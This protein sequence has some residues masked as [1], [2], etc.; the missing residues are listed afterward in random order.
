MCVHETYYT[1][2]FIPRNMLFMCPICCCCCSCCQWWWWLFGRQVEPYISYAKMINAKQK[3][4]GKMLSKLSN[5]SSNK[6]V[7]CE[8]L[9]RRLSLSMYYLTVAC[10]RIARLQ[11]FFI[12]N[13]QWKGMERDKFSS[14]PFVYLSLFFNM[15]ESHNNNNNKTWHRTRIIILYIFYLCVA[16]VHSSEFALIDAFSKQT[17]A[18]FPMNKTFVWSI[19]CSV[20]GWCQ[21]FWRAFVWE[22]F[23][24]IRLKLDD[25]AWNCA[26][27][28]LLTFSPLNHV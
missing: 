24:L 25:W 15:V 14:I 21:Q 16:D 13:G 5:I 1:Q 23:R 19:D 26:I 17:L 11:P 4:G 28:F 12:S 3:H 22:T 10:V 6:F 8:F 18:F 2:Y 20:S 7:L 27:N 9:D